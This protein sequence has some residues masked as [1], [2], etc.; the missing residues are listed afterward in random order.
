MTFEE[1][2]EDCQLTTIPDTREFMNLVLQGLC[3]IAG[4]APGGGGGD[5][6]VDLITKD[7][8]TETL[9]MGASNTEIIDVADFAS[10][11]VAVSGTFTGTVTFSASLDGTTYDIATLWGKNVAGESVSTFTAPGTFFFNVGLLNKVKLT[12]T[13]IG[14]GTANLVIAK[15]TVPLE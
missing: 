6:T 5:V 12:V 10:L 8:S 13:T 15:S 7:V 2:C 11:A 14:S 9:G 4:A 1:Y 3:A